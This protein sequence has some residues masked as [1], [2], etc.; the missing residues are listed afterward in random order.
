[1]QV[2]VALLLDWLRALGPWRALVTGLTAWSL[3]WFGT[4]L[5][6]ANHSSLDS[7]WLDA[8]HSAIPASLGTV[9]LRVYQL[10]GKHVTGLLVLA[11]VIVMVW[12]RFWPELL[13]FLVGTGGIVLIVDRWLKPLFNRPRPS[14]VLLEDISGRSFPSGHA[15]GSVVFYFLACCLL[16]AH[17]P[18]LRRP[19]FLVSSIW[20]ALVWLSTLYCRAH[21]LSDIAAGAAVGY[22]WLSFCLAGFT[23]WEQRR[24]LRL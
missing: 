17:Y 21:W 24:R 23:V 6:Q 4:H 22:V 20:V 9:L 15:A 13:C 2:V 14:G 1:M 12:K 8:I 11:V 3:A 16:S 10:S 19:L 7:A 18:H 5:G